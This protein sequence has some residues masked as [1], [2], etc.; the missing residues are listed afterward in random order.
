MSDKPMNDGNDR[1]DAAV[2]MNQR[3]A[4]ALERVP[5]VEIPAGFAARVAGQLPARRVVGV[6]PARYGMMAT[7][8]AVVVLSIAIVVV[9]LRAAGHSMFGITLEWILCGE[10]V[11]LSMWMGGLWRLSG[12]EA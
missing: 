11:G 9:A 10:L 1:M 4:A 5:A 12:P 3:L 7:R 6:T 2:G 8:V